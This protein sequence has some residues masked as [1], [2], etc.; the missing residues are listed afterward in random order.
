MGRKHP[1]ECEKN[2]NKSEKNRVV[3]VYAQYLAANGCQILCIYMCI[4]FIFFVKKIKN[5]H[6]YKIL[7]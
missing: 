1:N 5:I 2:T 6:M 3:H 4:F 7:F